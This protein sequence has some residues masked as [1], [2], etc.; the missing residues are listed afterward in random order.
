MRTLPARKRAYYYGW[1]II[2]ICVLVQLVILGVALNCFALFVPIWA[3][4]MAAPVSEIL[5]AVTLFTFLG[6]GIGPL[7]GW[8]ADRFPSNILIGSGLLV[9][10]V[11]YVVGAFVK[12]P[13]ELILIYAFLV[14]PAVGLSTTI[15]AQAVV[16]R[17][18]ERKRGLA[19]GLNAFGIIL[20]GVL[21]PPVVALLLPSLG[22]QGIWLV[23]AAV[24]GLIVAPLAFL[25]LYDRPSPDDPLTHVENA[26]SEAAGQAVSFGT[27]LARPNFW[28]LFFVCITALCPYFVATTNIASVA[29]SHGLD[30]RAAG[31]LLSVLF[32]ADLAGKLLLGML[33]DKIGNRIP[34]V[35]VALLAAIGA[36]WLIVANSAPMVFLAMIPLG[37]SGGIWT[38]L[39]SSAAAEFGTA[40][41]GR[42]FGMLTVSAPFAMLTVPVVARIKEQTGSYSTSLLALAIFAVVGAAVA[43]LLRQPGR[44]PTTETEL[45][46]A[47]TT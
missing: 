12:T 23:S 22:W 47:T 25:T 38:L 40:S 35:L 6:P 7:I 45:R 14:A 30:L 18:F 8:A 29:Q 21:F 27:I 42:A 36:A 46:P 37:M 19:M 10:T 39:P 34:L 15:S 11:A 33:A 28:L 13:I 5:L 20:A 26:S 32:A 17:W 31:L 16:C 43:A 3:K 9:A 24:N 1:N 2:A 4:Q 41:F 44:S